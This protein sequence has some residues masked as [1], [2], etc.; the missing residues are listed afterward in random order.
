MSDCDTNEVSQMVRD[1]AEGFSAQSKLGNRLWIT[2]MVL[3]LVVILPGQSKNCVDPNRYLPFGIGCID[4]YYFDQVSFFMLAVLTIA[5]CQA[6]AETI[7]GNRR[8][9]NDIDKMGDRTSELVTSQRAFFDS[10]S[11]PS[12]SRVGSLPV[13]ILA[14]CGRTHC[15]N[16]IVAIY[17]LALKV[18]SVGVH[19]G[20]P[21]VSLF[22]VGQRLR[23]NESIAFWVLCIGYPTFFVTFLASAQIFIIEFIH[24]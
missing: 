24:V 23:G 14:K 16:V 21:I 12:L 3:I 5:F 17:Y 15:I 20:I 4:T 22:Y 7:R 8:A 13:L 10:L 6:H 2:L 1:H 18:I 9:Q 11:I 19:I